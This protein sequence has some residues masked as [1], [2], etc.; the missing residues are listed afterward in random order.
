MMN[1]SGFGWKC[2][3]MSTKKILAY[4]FVSCFIIFIKWCSSLF[5]FFF[6]LTISF[7]TQNILKNLMNL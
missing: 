2:Y 5:F 1:L 3:N 7:P 6:F 4:F